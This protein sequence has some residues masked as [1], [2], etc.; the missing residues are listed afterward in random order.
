M[1]Y[2]DRTIQPVKAIHRVLEPEWKQPKNARVR[3]TFLQAFLC[4][5]AFR[6]AS[7]LQNCHTKQNS[8]MLREIVRAYI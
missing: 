7:I 6:F 2:A 1:D 5:C 3:C 8:C 4:G